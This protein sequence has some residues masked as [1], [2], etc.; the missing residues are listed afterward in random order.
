MHGNVW[1]W[2]E[3]EWHDSYQEK[4]DRLKQNGNEAWGG[5][6]TNKNDNRSHSVR[7][8]SWSYFPR[9]CRSACRD[10]YTRVIRDDVIGFRVCCLPARTL[11]S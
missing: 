8:G 4:P 2:C 1:E 11:V 7:G 5:S 6:S 9:L 3:D 10:F